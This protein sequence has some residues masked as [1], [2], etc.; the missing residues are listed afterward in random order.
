[1]VIS[2]QG[3]LLFGDSITA[4]QYIAPRYRWTSVFTRDLEA[5][6]PG[7]YDVEVRAV[8]GETS[9]Q[10]LIR[11]PE[12]IVEWPIDIVLLQF[13]FN[14]ANYWLS[15]G[16]KH[17]RVSLGAFRENLLEM[18]DR[19]R[20]AGVYTVILAT[21]H[22]TTKL[23]GDGRSLQE[24]KVAYDHVA[25]EVAVATGCPLFDAAAV[26]GQFTVSE[27]GELLLPYPD[28]LHLSVEGHEI[29]GRAFAEFF[30]FSIRGVPND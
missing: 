24:S 12:L 17:P 8:S 26:F 20:L 1:M 13:G 22:A 6:F 4:G 7:E 29:Y 14:D 28:C 5:S 3:V 30:T 19:A 10:A 15:E 16:G 23:I 11:F 27:L 25:R 2:R 9:R 18:V 21:N